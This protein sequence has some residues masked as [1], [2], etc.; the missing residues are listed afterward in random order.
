MIQRIINGILSF[1]SST[2][3]CPLSYY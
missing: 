2:S 3:R 1:V